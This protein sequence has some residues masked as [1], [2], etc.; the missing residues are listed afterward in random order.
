M[1]KLLVARCNFAFPVC[2]GTPIES[3]Q[4]WDEDKVMHPRRQLVASLDDD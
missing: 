4:I 2:C 3:N 1:G